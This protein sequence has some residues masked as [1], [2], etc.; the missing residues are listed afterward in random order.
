MRVG[1]VKVNRN[2]YVED[3]V[4]T[5]GHTPVVL[6]INDEELVTKIKKSSIPHWIFTG[7]GI[8][9]SVLNP[10]AP[11]VPLEIFKM[12]DKHFVL[13]CYSMESVL[14]QMGYPIKQRYETK[15]ERIQL[16]GLHVYRNHRFYTPVS[17]LDSTIQIVHSYRGELMTAIYKN[18]VMTQWHPERSRDGVQL[19]KGW[20][21]C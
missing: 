10:L 4:R 20:I 2:T 17:S 1:V 11:Q 19:L 15:K 14:F 7:T 3:A 13:I 6:Q 9:V 5:L 8:A 12:K 16:D 18:A 21:E